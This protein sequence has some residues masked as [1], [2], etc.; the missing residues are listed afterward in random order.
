[1]RKRSV[2][3]FMSGLAVVFL[4]LA[5]WSWWQGS[6]VRFMLNIVVANVWACGAM[7]ARLIQPMRSAFHERNARAN[8]SID[9]SE[10]SE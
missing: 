7:L 8:R 4:V 2:D 1:M 3:T 6:D 5:A 10:R 9:D